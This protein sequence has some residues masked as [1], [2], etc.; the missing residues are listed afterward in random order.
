MKKFID[1]RLFSQEINKMGYGIFASEFISKD[2]II[3]VS[4]LLLLTKPSLPKQVSLLKN[5]FFNYDSK[6]S[7]IALGYG[8]IYNHTDDGMQT[9]DYTVKKNVMV[10]KTIKDVKKYQQLTINYGYWW[11]FYKNLNLKNKIIFAKNEKN[12]PF[13]ISSKIKI[14]NDKLYAIEDIQEGEKVE[15]AHGLEFK[16]INKNFPMKKFATNFFLDKKQIY[17]FPFG[18]ASFYIIKDEDKANINYYIENKK[19]HFVAKRKIEKGEALSV[20]KTNIYNQY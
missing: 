15:V 12:Q 4:K 20:F 2:T 17:V 18:F 14:K 13:F 16:K 6:T 7:A 8:S 19:V 10:Y 3:E 5:Y 1:K 9:V 11:A